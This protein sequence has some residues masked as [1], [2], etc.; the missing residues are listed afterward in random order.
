MKHM[1]VSEYLARI[2]FHTDSLRKYWLQNY[3]LNFIAA[4]DIYWRNNEF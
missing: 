4:G 2:L 1:P 3:V